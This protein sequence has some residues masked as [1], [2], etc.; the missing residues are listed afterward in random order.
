MYILTIPLIGAVTL[1][2]IN[3]LKAMFSG[4]GVITRIL[5]ALLS[6]EGK[7]ARF[8]STFG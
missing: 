3:N 4:L 1:S 5:H 8:R 2:D 6:L 7:I